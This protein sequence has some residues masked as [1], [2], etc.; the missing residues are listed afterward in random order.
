MTHAVKPP[1]SEGIH[2]EELGKDPF[3]IGF[4]KRFF[5]FLSLAKVHV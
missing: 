1:P 2:A 4:F 5:P 3:L